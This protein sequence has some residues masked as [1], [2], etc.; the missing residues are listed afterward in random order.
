MSILA[1]LQTIKVEEVAANAPSSR[2]VSK[3]WNPPADT[4]RIRVWN[5]GQVYPSKALVDKFD[6]EYKTAIITKTDVPLKEGEV[7]AEGEKP[8]VKRTYEYANGAGNGFDVISSLEWG[9]YKAAPDSPNFMAIAV[10]PKTEPKVDLFG[11][12][13]FKDDGTP[14]ATV[15][16]QGSSS[17]GKDTLLPMLETVYG[18]KLKS[19]EN[20][21]APAF[22]DMQID[23]SF[24]LKQLVPNGV[25]L[26]PKTVVRGEDKGKA[27]FVRRE[28]VS[29]FAFEPVP[30]EAVTE[31]TE[32]VAAEDVD[33]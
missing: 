18:V 32:P 25:F 6:L 12:T 22:V 26:F 5:N 31:D 14:T 11:N 20:P 3:E 9:Q 13:K 19:E 24:D 23:D 28:N 17:Y 7:L 10:V 2:G 33:A 30:A 16:E 15:L 27:D 1:F 4:L 8:K 29:M 21:D